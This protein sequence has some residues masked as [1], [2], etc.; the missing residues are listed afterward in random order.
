MGLMFR[1]L[2]GGAQRPA[3]PIA[4]RLFDPPHA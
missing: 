2:I 4:I 3:K 1:E